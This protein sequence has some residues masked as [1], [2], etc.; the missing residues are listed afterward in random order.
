MFSLFLYKSPKTLEQT[1]LFYLFEHLETQNEI[2]PVITSVP[3]D[4]PLT[5]PT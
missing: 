5:I 4:Q 2:S 3:M 1:P